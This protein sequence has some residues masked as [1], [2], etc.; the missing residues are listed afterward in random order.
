M[1]GTAVRAT[2]FMG[3]YT[4]DLL[5]G[6]LDASEIEDRFV[7]VSGETRTCLALVDDTTGVVTEVLEPGPRITEDEWLELL[8][9]LPELA[10]GCPLCIIAGSLPPGVPQDAYRV[11]TERLQTAGSKVLLDASGV[12]LDRALPARPWMIKINEA[13]AVAWA[14]ADLIAAICRLRQ[15]SEV[16]VVTRGA[17]GALLCSRA[18]SW[19]AS[20]PPVPVKSAV[21]S[22]D[23]FSAGLAW[24]LLSGYDL[25]SG[26]QAAVAAGAANAM[27]VQTGYLSRDA[28]DSLRQ[29][30]QVSE[31]YGFL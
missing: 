13:E 25:Q 7:R 29:Q 4:G 26:L 2:G 23:A 16:V 10:S 1:L 5:R 30:V 18:G 11:I 9:R 31:F 6:Q 14:G 24:A 3:G 12:A 8:R 17:K 19:Q 20:P 28:F 27:A 21:G 22:G 15:W